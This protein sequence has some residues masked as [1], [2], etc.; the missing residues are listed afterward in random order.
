MS[1]KEYVNDYDISLMKVAATD[2][3]LEASMANPMVD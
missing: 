2:T 1:F 3:F